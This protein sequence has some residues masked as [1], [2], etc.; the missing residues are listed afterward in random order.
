M[1]TNIDTTHAI[2][3]I[4]SWLKQ[5]PI[6]RLENVDTV[7][8]MDALRIIMN[9]NVFAF[10]DTFWI[11]LTGTA[12]GTPPAPMYAT[13]YFAIHEAEVI[14]TYDELAYY[15][16]YIDDGFGMWV[17][18]PTHSSQEDNIQW[19]KFKSNYC[20]YGNLSWVF[21]ERTQESTY[22]DVTVTFQSNGHAS[23]RLYE[24]ALNLY[25]YLPAHSAHPP[26][27]L[28][29]LIRGTYFRIQR[30][31][32]EPRLRL[33][34][35]RQLHLRLLARGYPS[36][37]LRPLFEEAITD[38]SL[39]RKPTGTATPPLFLHVP[40]HPQDPN[41]RQIQD[42]FRT[43]MLQPPNEPRLPTLCNTNG[44]PLDID[45]LIIA[46]HKPRNLGNILAPRRLSPNGPD[47]SSYLVE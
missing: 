9:H 29:G 4:E 22:L 19:T 21:S 20:D 12:M 38:Y 40:Y 41:S 13:L 44:K 8:L 35:F 15:R 27:V 23:T 46:Y 42:A 7:A 6:P 37:L 36:E 32:S 33:S 11:Q 28:K 1:Y 26:G 47:V 18:D 34:Q 25:L 2:S 39:S 24:K 3:T 10:G 5:S 43:T 16:R 17:P 31:T 45:R 30:L 14:P